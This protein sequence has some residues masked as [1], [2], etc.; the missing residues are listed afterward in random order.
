MA[1]REFLASEAGW[2]A[3]GAFEAFGNGPCTILALIKPL[4]FNA[5]G[6][7]W[8]SLSGATDGLGSLADGG[9]GK[10]AWFTA[11]EDARASVG[12]TADDWQILAWT[13]GLEADHPR[14][15]RK[16]RGSGVWTHVAATGSAITYK[17]DPLADIRIGSFAASRVGVVAI[18][19]QALSD[20]DLEAIDAVASTQL[21]A[22][23][24][25]IHLWEFTQASAA[26]AV[27]DVAGTAHQTSVSSGTIVVTDDDPAGWTFGVTVIPPLDFSVRLSGGAANDDPAASFGGAESSVEVGADLF[28][29]V[30]NSERVSGLTDYRLVYV[31]NEDEADGSVIAYVSTQLES[32]RQIAVGVP[33]Q[34]AGATVPAIADDQ[35]APVGVAFSAPTTAPAGVALDTIPAAGFRGLWLRRTVTSGTA[36][37]PTN[38]ATVKLEVAR[39]E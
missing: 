27:Q 5:S 30:T 1:V 32:G 34:L 20:S 7:Q 23:L 36:Q 17:S 26:T 14:G 11:S 35:T 13:K 29:D 16:V 28:D 15:H 19:D 12:E 2:R 18:F 22:D 6:Q 8:V 10:L 39:V 37:D 38:L 24:G 25:A 31:H 4:T 9:T 3:T 33:T 21:I